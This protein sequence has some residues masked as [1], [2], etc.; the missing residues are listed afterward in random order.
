MLVVVN[1]CLCHLSSPR[2]SSG[3]AVSYGHVNALAQ[4]RFGGA[5]LWQLSFSQQLPSPYAASH[6]KAEELLSGTTKTYSVPCTVY[7]VAVLT[8][9]PIGV[10][11][12]RGKSDAVP[13]AAGK[14]CRPI[15]DASFSRCWPPHSAHLLCFVV[16]GSRGSWRALGRRRQ[17][18]RREGIRGGGARPR[19][20]LEQN[21]VSIYRFHY[22]LCRH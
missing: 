16:H 10:W 11:L 4:L 6:K 9:I 5:G 19:E 17:W 22:S 12:S 1:D 13:A 2:A 3:R 20:L 21:Y 7:E 14:R 15:N 18:P 8:P